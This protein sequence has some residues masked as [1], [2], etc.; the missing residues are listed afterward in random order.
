MT[1][2]RLGCYILRMSQYVRELIYTTFITTHWS[3]NIF[4]GGSRLQ[5][6]GVISHHLNIFIGGSFHSA[7]RLQLTG[8]LT[9]VRTS[10]YCMFTKRDS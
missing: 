3:L 9:T 4:I 1:A 2:C 10:H 7:C 8:I 6:T 5:L